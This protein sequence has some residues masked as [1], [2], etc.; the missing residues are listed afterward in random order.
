MTADNDLPHSDTALSRLTLTVMNICGG[1]QL[2]PRVERGHIL[3]SGT[4]NRVTGEGAFRY[5]CLDMNESQAQFAFCTYMT[6]TY[7]EKHC[8]CFIIGNYSFKIM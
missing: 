6:L 5:L 4:H 2:L 7:H 8:V 3:Y 1:Q